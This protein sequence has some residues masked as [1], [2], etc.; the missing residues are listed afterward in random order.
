MEDGA[1]GSGPMP[2]DGSGPVPADGPGPAPAWYTS[3]L[4][5]LKS[6]YEDLSHIQ[7]IIEGME[8]G[9]TWEKM[10]YEYN[11]DVWG[12]ELGRPTLSDILELKL[13][14]T[15][16]RTTLLTQ[17]GKLT[18]KQ[19]KK[20]QERQKL[21]EAGIEQ[22]KQQHALD[23]AAFLRREAER[24]LQAANADSDS[25]THRAGTGS[26]SDDNA[27]RLFFI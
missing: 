27:L 2:A 19:I 20:A 5:R 8:P 18:S 15:N 4:Q 3:Q 24:R 9:E 26:D 25:G 12:N 13:D 1:D 16:A 21:H 11:N 10:P 7:K 6:E 23:R 22:A 17:A 14:N